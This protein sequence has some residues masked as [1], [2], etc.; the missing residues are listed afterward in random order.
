MNFWWTFSVLKEDHTYNLIFWRAHYK[1][2]SDRHKFRSINPGNWTKFKMGEFLLANISPCTYPNNNRKNKLIP[3]LS[4][5]SICPLSSSV[6]SLWE[7]LFLHFNLGMPYLFWRGEHFSINSLNH[8]KWVLVKNR[9][10]ES[11]KIS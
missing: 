11:P 2:I 3:F 8:V 10:Q 1:Q 9:L 5:Y 6:F 4:S 7:T